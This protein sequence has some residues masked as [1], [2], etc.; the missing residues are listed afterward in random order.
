[1]SSLKDKMKPSAKSA[2]EKSASVSESFRS[3]EADEIDLKPLNVRISKELHT[4][5]KLYAAA[6]DMKLQVLVAAALQ[7]YLEKRA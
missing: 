3:A 5:V 4:Q 7:E 2:N 1:M 6:N